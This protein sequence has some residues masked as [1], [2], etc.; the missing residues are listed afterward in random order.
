MRTHT[1]TKHLS[2]APRTWLALSL[3]LLGSACAI[4]PTTITKGPSTTRP[5]MPSS[6]AYNSG[7]IY[8]P[9]TYR[10]LLE[11][12]RARLVGDTV[13]INITENTTA[14]KAGTNSASKTGEV[15]AGIPSF[16]GRTFPRL[17]GSGSSD[18]SYNDAAASNSRNVFTG[19][20]SATV[21]EVLPN[22]N[23]IVSGEKQVAFD[24]GTEFVRFSGVIDPMYISAGNN[25]PS[26]RVA[27][28][29]IEY[30]TNSQID[31]A[32]AMSILTRFFLSVA[33]L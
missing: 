5:P 9:A 31:A 3:L 20:I 26:S 10:P 4:P 13:V 23:M 24:R 15:T 29:R 2:L 30:R 18:L 11:D 12:K 7:G 17:S 1:I 14:T 27:D 25:V 32:Q 22:G 6:A 8:N 33:P 19:T 16:L 21:M 28:A